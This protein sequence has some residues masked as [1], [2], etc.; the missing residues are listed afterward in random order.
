VIDY[1]L[2]LLLKE[3]FSIYSIFLPAINSMASLHFVEMILKFWTFSLIVRAYW[4]IK[5]VQVLAN[6]NREANGGEGGGLPNQ[7]E[8]C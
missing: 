6:V 2:L 5:E 8:L 4:Q 1:L 3:Q 7:I